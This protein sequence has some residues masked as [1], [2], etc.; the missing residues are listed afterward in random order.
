MSL[1]GVA[2]ARAHLEFN[3][4]GGTGYGQT[5]RFKYLLMHFGVLSMLKCGRAQVEI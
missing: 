1:D 3:I 4:I 5:D 2:L